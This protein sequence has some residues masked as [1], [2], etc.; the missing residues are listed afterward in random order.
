MQ[1]ITSKFSLKDFVAYLFPGLTWLLA[2]IAMLATNDQIRSSMGS[3]SEIEGFSIVAILFGVPVSYLLGAVASSI[4]SPFEKVIIYITKK[5][6]LLY[7]SYRSNNNGI[8]EEKYSSRILWE[9][10]EVRLLLRESFKGMPEFNLIVDKIKDNN[11]YYVA[12]TL[13]GESIPSVIDSSARQDSLRQMR[14]NSII[15]I[16]F[17]GI[18]GLVWTECKGKGFDP[19]LVSAIRYISIYLCPF[20]VIILFSGIL[21][22][23]YRRERDVLIGLLCTPTIL[24]WKKGKK[25]FENSRRKYRTR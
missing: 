25:N 19:N 10:S 18:T 8:S 14:R 3:V 9:Y 20:I 5:V 22:N 23:N 11:L 2:I 7:L 6:E 16:I 21:H 15:P 4:A 12:R 17:W 1:G 13:V 24:S